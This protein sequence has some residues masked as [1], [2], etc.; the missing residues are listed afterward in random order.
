MFCEL[1]YHQNYILFERYHR[2]NKHLMIMLA[3]FIGASQEV[4]TQFR[5]MKSIRFTDP[6]CQT[7]PPTN[8]RYQKNCYNAS[9][10]LVWRVMRFG[11][12]IHFQ[13]PWRQEVTIG[14]S[15]K[16]ESFAGVIDIEG[17]SRKPPFWSLSDSQWFFVRNCHLFCNLFLSFLDV[18]V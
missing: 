15:W 13:N 8:V 12:R 17:F 11:F 7:I 5:R 18:Y 1:S 3:K 16:F 9:W 4:R 6:S 2:R 10:L 14:L